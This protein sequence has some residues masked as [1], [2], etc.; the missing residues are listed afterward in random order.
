MATDVAEIILQKVL[1]VHAK[2]GLRVHLACSCE[3]VHKEDLMRLSVTTD[4]LTICTCGTAAVCL[5]DLRATTTVC[6]ELA[7]YVIHMVRSYDAFNDNGFMHDYML[8]VCDLDGTT[9]YQK[10]ITSFQRARVAKSLQGV[11][12]LFQYCTYCP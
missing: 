4:G 2:V 7:N 3:T 6:Q 1:K 12:D 8:D 9:V 11:I 5:R 10:A